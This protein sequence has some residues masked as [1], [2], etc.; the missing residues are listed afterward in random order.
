MMVEPMLAGRFNLIMS[1]FNSAWRRSYIV[2][3]GSMSKFMAAVELIK[4]FM[5]RG[6]WPILISLGN[7]F[8]ALF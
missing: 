8:A 4:V 2:F 1:R 5:Q 7:G 3:P 6:R